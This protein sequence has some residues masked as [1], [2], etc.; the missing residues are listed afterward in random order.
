MNVLRR[1]FP[2]LPLLFGLLSLALFVPGIAIMERSRA[3]LPTLQVAV[4]ALILAVVSMV[5]AAAIFRKKPQGS[6]YGLA[7]TGSLTGGFSVVFWLVM[8]PMMLIF[9]I[10]ARDADPVEPVVEQS[11]EQMRIWVRHIKTFYR[12]EGRFPVKLEE[13]VDKG[14]AQDYLLYDPRQALKDAP[15]YRLM[16]QEMPPESEWGRIPVLEGRIPHP[17]DGTRLLAY[18]DETVGQTAPA[19]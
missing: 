15:S 2:V 14:Y 9:A 19:E 13:L 6:V 16:L 4:P 18:L 10:P 17:R 3:W 12:D 1:P 11:R 7:M 5:I 8:V